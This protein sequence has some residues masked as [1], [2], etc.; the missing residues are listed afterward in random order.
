MWPLVI[1]PSE[2]LPC[3]VEIRNV[4]YAHED[5]NIELAFDQEAIDDMEGYQ[6][7]DYSDD[8]VGDTGDLDQ[9]LC[10]PRF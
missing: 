9:I 6:Y 2:E 7:D 3:K 4:S 10:R 1:A 8:Q 5:E